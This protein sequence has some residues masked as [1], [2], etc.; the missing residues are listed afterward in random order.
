MQ[1]EWIVFSCIAL[2]SLSLVFVGAVGSSTGGTTGTERTVNA[3]NAAACETRT[4]VK[5]RIQCR[6]QFK[7][8]V[9]SIEE[10]CRALSIEKQAACNRLQNNA[11]P[12]YDKPATEKAICLRTNAGLGTGQLNRYAAPERRQYAALLMYE[13]QER[14]EAKQDAGQLSDEQAAE[15]IAQIVEIKQL[16]LKNE[17]LATVKEKMASFKTAYLEAMRGAA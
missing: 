14:I 5:D 2:L 6:M 4:T 16:L 17:P 7:S 1:K 13:L 8:N 11:A 9:Q 10:S 3:V 15:L 12:C